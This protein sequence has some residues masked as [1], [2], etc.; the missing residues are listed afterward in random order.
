MHL[1]GSYILDEGKSIF[2]LTKIAKHD[3]LLVFLAK[4]A[5]NQ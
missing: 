5:K 2:D 3:E 1:Q 4:Y